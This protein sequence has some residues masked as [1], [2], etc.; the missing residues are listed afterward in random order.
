[1]L[2]CLL[3]QRTRGR[4]VGPWTQ[5]PATLEHP[6]KAPLEHPSK[7]SKAPTLQ[8]PS[9]AARLEHPSK[10][11]SVVELC[12]PVPKS[13]IP[14]N[15]NPKPTRPVTASLA[16][17]LTGGDDKLTPSQL[18]S[19]EIEDDVAKTLAN[20]DGEDLKTMVDP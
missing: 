19:Q 6:S 9:E 16:N 10:V 12:P 8:H 17:A 5:A 20:V 7:A 14:P 13:S 3:V 11:A 15:P 18:W 1:M 2:L 4:V